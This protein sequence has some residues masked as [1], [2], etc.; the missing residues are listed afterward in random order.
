MP[1]IA[2]RFS[3]IMVQCAFEK[4]IN[5]YL[6]KIVLDRPKSSITDRVL[7]DLSTTKIEIANS[8]NVASAASYRS[9][10]KLDDFESLFFGSR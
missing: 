5:P 4:F 9:S 3:N 6:S 1:E 7:Y 8:H 2:D 10:L